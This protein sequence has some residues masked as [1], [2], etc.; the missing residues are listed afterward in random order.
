MR[1][2]AQTSPRSP[3]SSAPKRTRPRDRFSCAWRA[4]RRPLSMPPS[5]TRAGLCGRR[6]AQRCIPWR[7]SFAVALAD[8]D[9]QQTRKVPAHICAVGG[10]RPGRRYIGDRGDHVA[11][12]LDPA[13]ARAAAGGG[14]QSDA[15]CADQLAEPALSERVAGDG[16]GGRAPRRS[17]ARDPLFRSRRVQVGQR[18]VRARSGRPG[19]PGDGI[20][21][22]PNPANLRF[23]C[24]SRRRRICRGPARCGH[25]RRWCRC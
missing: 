4:G 20:T 2:A 24:S 25:P 10:C 8:L 17:A 19:A 5:P 13:D 14:A 23:R 16:A 15:R 21:I 7:T 22:A 6:F 3:G 1:C 9:G 18:P 12:H 11:E